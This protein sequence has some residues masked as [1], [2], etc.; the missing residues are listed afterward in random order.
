M[1]KKKVAVAMSGGVDSSVAACLLKEEGREV[2]GFTMK[3]YSP[4]DGSG[5]SR[6]VP[7]LNE[8]AIE[9]AAAVAHMIGIEHFVVDVER[10]FKKHVL[11]N[12]CSEYLKGRTP[13]PCVVCNENVKFGVLFKEAIKH[14]AMLATGHYVK[15]EHCDTTDTFFLKRGVD[16]EKDQSYM[17]YRLDQERMS[18]LIMP[19]GS[20]LKDDVRRMARERKLPIAE[21]LESQDICFA[22]AKEY[23]RFKNEVVPQRTKP[24]VI[25]NSKGE[26]LGTHKG[27][28]NYTIGQRR[29]LGIA[30][31]E[32]LYVIRIDID[33]N[34]II[35]G[36]KDECFKRELIADN[37]H[38]MSGKPPAGS[39]Q[40]KAK[41]R[42]L[43]EEADAIVDQR[44]D[45]KILVRFFEPQKAITPGQ[46]VV[47]YD[48]DTVLGGGVI[49]K[50]L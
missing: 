22:E 17:L 20:L 27:I 38:F 29:G 33:T 39:F 14:N 40:A 47:F 42:Y 44:E 10:E 21:R 25:K 31:P 36:Y 3:T 23:M 37:V 30:A 13:N 2:I 49:E 28:T 6:P 7:T 5:R 8:K 45:N 35:V 11:D 19:M 16:R 24:G 12:F 50:S 46:S 34:E 18:R 43:H 4:T 1:K 26:I 15:I 48:G 32:P 9:D 41:I